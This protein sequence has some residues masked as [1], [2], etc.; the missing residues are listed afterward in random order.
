MFFFKSY[1]TCF[2][3]S[4]SLTPIQLRLL[5]T[6][7]RCFRDFSVAF[8]A[9]FLRVSRLWLSSS[10]HWWPL[11]RTICQMS[12]RKKKKQWKCH[13]DLRA[14]VLTTLTSWNCV[15]TQVE[16]EVFLVSS[17]EHGSCWFSHFFCRVEI[18]LATTL[19]HWLSNQSRLCE[20]D[21]NVWRCHNTSNLQTTPNKN[22]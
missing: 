13:A 22:P 7:G 5:A 14:T 17:Q 6:S 3:T 12:N 1:W 9:A 2:W 4:Q 10:P 8:A 18:A 15:P 11:V 20:S 19:A 16:G 21:S